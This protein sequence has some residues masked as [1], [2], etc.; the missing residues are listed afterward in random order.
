MPRTTAL[1]GLGTTIYIYIYIYRERERER[2]RESNIRYAYNTLSIQAG[3]D[4]YLFNKYVSKIRQKN[5]E[6]EN[7]QYVY[8]TS[9]IRLYFKISQ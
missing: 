4:W 9:I 6:K 1:I 2:E 7:T 5:T 8:S 3:I